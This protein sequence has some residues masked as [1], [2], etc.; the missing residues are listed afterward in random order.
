MG[1]VLWEQRDMK[2][3]G[4]ITSLEEDRVDKETRDHKYFTL[5]LKMI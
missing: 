2:A 4:L 1:Y 3:E 5:V